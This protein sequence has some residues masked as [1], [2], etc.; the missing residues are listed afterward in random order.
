[1]Y[2]SAGPE[3]S[4]S[5]KRFRPR[6]VRSVVI[7]LVVVLCW[8]VS[9]TLAGKTSRSAGSPICQGRLT[10]GTYALGDSVMEGAQSYLRSCGVTVDAITSRQFY[11]GIEIVQG[12]RLAGT[13][14]RQMVI[15]LGTNGPFTAQQFDEMMS[16]LRTVSRVVFVTVK[17]PRFWE[18]QV[19]QT[20]RAGVGRW[21]NARLADWYSRAVRHPGWTCCDGIHIGPAGARAYTR[22]V[23]KALVA[24]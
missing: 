6:A 9:H 18:G 7:A 4:A 23:E 16:N 3:E 21:H 22:I 24:R 15:G 12:M 19:N 5:V 20:L 10:V 8:P 14:P 2:T 13:L 17:E 1:M 11:Q